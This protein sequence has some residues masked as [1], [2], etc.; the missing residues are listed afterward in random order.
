MG[1]R[2]G[3]WRRVRLTRPHRDHIGG[4][5]GVGFRRAGC[6]YESRTSRTC[7]HQATAIVRHQLCMGIEQ[8]F[9]DICE[10][11]IIQIELALHGPIGYSTA[12]LQHG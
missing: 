8:G 7:P 2:V 6:G 1:W 9:L 4:G 12:A 3:Q 10:R 5:Q 11:C